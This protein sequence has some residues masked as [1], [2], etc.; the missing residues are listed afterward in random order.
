M[1]HHITVACAQVREFV[2]FLSRH[3][4]KHRRFAVN[5]LVMG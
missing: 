5:D 3:L 2:R 4:A 1:R